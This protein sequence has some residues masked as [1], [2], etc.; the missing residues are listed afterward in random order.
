[1]IA[2]G[3]GCCREVSVNHWRLLVDDSKTKRGFSTVTDRGISNYR[4]CVPEYKSRGGG[5]HVTRP[6]WI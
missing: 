6:I 2:G 4:R 3:E 1:M 5:V